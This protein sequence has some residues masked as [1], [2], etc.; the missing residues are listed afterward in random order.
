M[1]GMCPQLDTLNL[2]LK[3]KTSEDSTLLQDDVQNQVRISNND[4][5][6]ISKRAI[7]LIHNIST[8]KG[9]VKDRLDSYW[10]G[11]LGIGQAFISKA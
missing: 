6:L 1:L 10:L 5:Q 7:R 4:P 2:T 3:W 8:Y 11:E 9:K